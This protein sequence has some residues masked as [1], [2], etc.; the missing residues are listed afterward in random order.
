MP[1]HVRAQVLQ[2][3]RCM[4]HITS[5]WPT[6]TRWPG[7]SA[8]RSRWGQ[9][10]TSRRAR[11]DL[12]RDHRG[13][14]VRVEPVGRRVRGRERRPLAGDH[15]PLILPADPRPFAGDR[16]AVRG[17]AIVDLQRVSG[18]E[19][20]LNRVA[21][22][23]PVGCRGRPSARALNA[24]PGEGCDPAGRCPARARLNRWSGRIRATSCSRRSRRGGSG[25]RSRCRP[26]RVIQRAAASFAP[27]RWAGVTI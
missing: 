4:A 14:D 2:C 15:I 5:R 8:P 18:D 25:R 16:I 9:Q 26:A 7:A 24:G 27:C 17:V 19:T 21:E 10:A 13:V 22:R 20:G 3:R 23:P 11:G 6:D 12:A 1:I